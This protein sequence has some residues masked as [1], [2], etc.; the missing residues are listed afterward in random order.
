VR[1]LQYDPMAGAFADPPADA[2]MVA[3]RKPDATLR[4][5]AEGYLL[6]MEQVAELMAAGLGE[7]TP[8]GR[9]LACRWAAA[10]ALFIEVL[11]Q[12]Q[13]SPETWH[14]IGH[15]GDMLEESGLLG[16]LCRRHGWVVVRPGL[17]AKKMER[18]RG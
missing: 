3:R 7:E 11:E 16:R 10:R 4:Q 15:P 6:E 5:R 2:P 13:P 18:R 8:A 1:P 12:H 9:L 14:V 17:L